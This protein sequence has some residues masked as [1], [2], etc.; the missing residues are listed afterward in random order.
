MAVKA[1]KFLSNLNFS[2]QK[3][4][5]EMELNPKKQQNKNHNTSTSE[6]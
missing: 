1:K 4:R 2:G 5:V 3:L 6:L